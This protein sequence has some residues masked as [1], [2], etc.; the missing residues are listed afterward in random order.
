MITR[1][2]L[3]ALALIVVAGVATAQSVEIN[4]QNRTIDLT[5]R[6]SVEVQADLVSITVGYH[7]WGPT[8]DA[9][10]DDN[11]R[12]AEQIL[13]VW[14]DAGVP[15]KEISTEDL[16][17]N[18]VSSDDLTGIPASE[19]KDRQY[20]AMQDWT[21]TAKP[22]VAQKLLDLGII[23]GANY[24]SNPQ[25]E[26]SDPNAAESKAYAAALA[27]AHAIAVQMADSFGAKVGHLLYASNQ[28]RLLSVIAGLATINAETS[29]VSP[30]SRK[31]PPLH[32]VKLL[33]QMIEKSATVRAV[34]ALE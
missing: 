10:Y 22:K 9:A 7:N 13:K 29:S 24:V 18:P 8:H 12:V 31:W 21:I 27:Q 5:T 14:T 1:G 6:S 28:T 17:S 30:G 4:P 11:M 16:S 34:F 19:R 2:S 3:V 33:P 20:E 15:Q 26:L 32:P 23:A 25:W